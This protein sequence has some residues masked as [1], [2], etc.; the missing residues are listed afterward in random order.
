M[1]NNQD[2]VFRHIGGRVVPIKLTP[3][4]KKRIAAL[5]KN[6]KELISG[7][8]EVAAAVGIGF[9]GGFGARALQKASISALKRGEKAHRL[10]TKRIMQLRGSE[11]QKLT[12]MSGK[13]AK[14]SITL[15]KLARFSRIGAFLGG[16]TLLETGVEKIIKAS[17]G[18]LTDSQEKIKE[19]SINVGTAAIA[20]AFLFGVGKFGVRKGFKDA[21]KYARVLKGKA[22]KTIGPKIPRVIKSKFSKQRELF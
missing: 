9:A 16:A 1:N 3:E 17:G 20:G 8:K 5:R 12:S 22:K 13:L 14:R 21:F 15:T 2:V 19:F 6:R 4:A 7:S 10:G 18:K 11:A